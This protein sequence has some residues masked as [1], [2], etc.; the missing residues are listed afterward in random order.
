MRLSARL[1]VVDPAGQVLLLDCLDP[2]RPSVRW[3]EVP[4]GGVE[5]GEDERAAAVREV[6]EETGVQVPLELVGPLQWTQDCTYR[7]RGRRHWARCH[8]Y[9]AQLPAAPVPAPPTLTDAEQGS[10]LGARW[11]T[12]EQVLASP[13]RFFPSGLPAQLPRLLAGER[14][15]EPFDRWD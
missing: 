6:A 9:V 10:L 4:G 13:V 5:P 2:A 1:L 11:W 3:W 12:V 8:G 15:D 7:W 14:V